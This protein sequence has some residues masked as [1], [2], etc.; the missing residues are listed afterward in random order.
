MFSICIICLLVPYGVF[1]EDIQGLNHF[2]FCENTIYLFDLEGKV[3]MVH[4]CLELMLIKLRWGASLS[5][6]G[7]LHKACP[8]SQRGQNREGIEA[9]DVAP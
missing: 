1:N 2:T 8:H 4:L 9:R 3:V 7:L 6:V 5:D